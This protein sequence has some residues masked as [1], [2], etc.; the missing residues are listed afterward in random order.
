[1]SGQMEKRNRH[2]KCPDR[3]VWIN[4]KEDYKRR[5]KHGSVVGFKTV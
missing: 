4:N 1:M 3:Q 2:K 5:S